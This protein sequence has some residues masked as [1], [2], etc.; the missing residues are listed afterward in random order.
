MLE[1]IGKVKVIQMDYE[2]I[3]KQIAQYIENIEQ[4]AANARG[5]NDDMMY[6]KN[7]KPLGRLII[8][9]ES[10]QHWSKR[11]LVAANRIKKSEEVIE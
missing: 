6:Y 1:S 3:E 9:L 2:K 10:I 4:L 8:E 5:Y 7:T 11:A